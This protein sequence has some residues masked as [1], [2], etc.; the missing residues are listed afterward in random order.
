MP[1][2]VPKYRGFLGLA[3]FNSKDPLRLP[4][5][6]TKR[7]LNRESIVYQ[8]ARNRMRGLARPV[9]TFLDSLYPSDPPESREEREI[10]KAV[11]P[12]DL[13][14]LARRSPSAWRVERPKKRVHRTTV[15]VQFD[16]EKEDLDRV[17]KR[18]RAPGMPANQ[19]GKY[20]FDFYLQME[21]LK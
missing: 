19:I 11:Q 16:A 6:T 13:A 17:R 7:G 9:L 15:K 18:L 8:M 2:F 10:A 1:S 21:G 14:E 3:F 5:T 20:T 4:W 12:A